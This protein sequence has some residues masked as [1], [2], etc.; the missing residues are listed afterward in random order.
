[1][2]ECSAIGANDTGILANSV[3]AVVDIAH[4]VQWQSIYQ[5]GLAVFIVVVFAAGSFVISHETNM[6]IVKPIE[7]MT[8]ILRK[9]AGTV[10]VLSMA[11][12][13]SFADEDMEIEVLE[14]IVCKMAEIFNVVPSKGGGK[15]KMDKGMQ[16]LA[17]P[18]SL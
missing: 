4:D 8:N 15:T 1:M 10:F 2:P 12:D 14:Q 9:L 18:I 17:G 13:P 11:E 5:M 16:M 7:R 3:D 6:L